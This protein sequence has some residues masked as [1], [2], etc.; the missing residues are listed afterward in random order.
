M[1]GILMRRYVKTHR[2]DGNVRM[3]AKAG[4][5]LP[6]AMEYQNSPEAGKGRK[7]IFLRANRGSMAL[8]A[9]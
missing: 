1:M 5:M 6:H 2:E 4:V 3:E 9:P 7:E 8:S